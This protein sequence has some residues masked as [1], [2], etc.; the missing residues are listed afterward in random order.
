MQQALRFVKQLGY[1]H[2]KPQ[3]KVGGLGKGDTLYTQLHGGK[4]TALEILG[5]LQ[6]KRLIKNIKWKILGGLKLKGKNNVLKVVSVDPVG[7][8]N[9]SVFSTSEK[10]FFASG[11]AMHNCDDF[12]IKRSNASFIKHGLKPPSPH[13]TVDTLKITRKYFKFNSNKLNDLCENLSLGC[14]V[15]TGGFDLWKGC[16]DGNL[17]AWRKMVKYNKHDIFLLEKLYKKLLPWMDNERSHN[18]ILADGKC[19]SCSLDK[20]KRKGY[21]ITQR[22]TFEKWQC[23]GCGRYTRGKSIR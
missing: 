9:V 4:F 14:K 11:Y 1:T 16:L 8:K 6:I 15:K 13:K 5:R 18:I 19:P 12:D 20:M 10:T 3:T 22:S 17:K 7:I 2:S 21:Y 23:E